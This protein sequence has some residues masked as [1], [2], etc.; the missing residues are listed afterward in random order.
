MTPLLISQTHFFNFY[1]TYL[2][3]K[4]RNSSA[5]AR[6]NIFLEFIRCSCKQGVVVDLAPHFHKCVSGSPQVEN[7]INLPLNHPRKNKR[8]RIWWV[9][10]PLSWGDHVCTSSWNVHE[11]IAFPSQ[12][13]IQVALGADWS[14]ITWGVFLLISL[15]N[16]QKQREHYERPFASSTEGIRISSF[17]QLKRCSIVT[18]FSWMKEHF[19]TLSNP[20]RLHR[21]SNVRVFC[22]LMEP[23]PGWCFVMFLSEILPRLSSFADFISILFGP[24]LIL[25]LATLWSLIFHSWDDSGSRL[26][27]GDVGV[28]FQW[29]FRFG[30]RHTQVHNGRSF[31]DAISD[32]TKVNREISTRIWKYNIIQQRTKLFNGKLGPMTMLPPR[33]EQKQLRYRSY[34]I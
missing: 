27:P 23:I 21:A 1:N 17:W 9:Q 2:F 22:S 32:I 29:F 18:S 6:R 4:F 30:P 33:T 15:R 11:W 7:I 28:K 3:L 19:V 16:A 34:N 8:V 25:S 31:S 26:F 14:T 24:R 20:G 5:V 10:W 12:N 13:A